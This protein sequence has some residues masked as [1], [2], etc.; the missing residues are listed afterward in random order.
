M[1]QIEEVDKEKMNDEMA[2]S[3][4]ECMY[5]IERD[6]VDIAGGLLFTYEGISVSCPVTTNTPN[7]YE[8]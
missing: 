4:E 7:D 6:V 1:L 2:T 3:V 8:G 5:I